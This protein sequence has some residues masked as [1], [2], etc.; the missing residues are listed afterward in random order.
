[1]FDREH[2]NSV[3]DITRRQARMQPDAVAQV[4]EGRVTTYGQLD[5]RS[6]RVAQ[7]FI[8]EGCKPDA[9]IG[10]IGKNSDRYFEMLHGAFKAKTVVVGVNWR[11]APPE[12]AYVLNDAK[13]EMIFVGAEFY[14]VVAQVVGECPT[15]RRV[16][17]LDGGHETWTSFDDWRDS[18][19]AT[20]PH[21]PDTMDD[22]VIQLYTSGTT[23]H[24]KGVQLTN[25]N[26]MA[27]LEEGQLSGWAKWNSD[28][29]V[30]V[31]MPLFHVAGVNI[32][33][34]GHAQ[35]TK[36]II[37]KD[38]DPQVI[39]RLI[40]QEK[41]N[42]AF[43]VPAVILFLLQQPN[44]NTTDVSSIR[45]ILYGASPIAEDVLKQ[46]QARFGCEF[47]QLYGLTETTGGA[48][49]LPPHAHDVAL[50]KLRSCGVP[51]PQTMIR[52]VDENGKDVPQG[53]VG[54]I[55]IKGGSVMKSYWNK[56][57]ATTESIKDGWFHSGDAGYFDADGYLYIHD[58]VK[59]MI[60]SGGENVYPAEVENALFGHPAIADVAVIGVPDERWGEA[61][62]A[63]VVLKPG[64]TAE[65]ADIIAF[66]KTRI[67][68]FKVPKS[69]D[70]V[71][72]LPRNPS[73]KIL[74]RELRSPYWEG[75][76]RM[77][78]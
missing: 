16:I 32:G 27:I 22:D 67:A 40:E 46:A 5:E 31:C 17:A 37:L 77:V 3:A 9:R 26:Y 74:R 29:V 54:E 57:Q 65:P 19:P 30:L 53:G 59:D 76:A 51:N 10:F 15:V 55:L 50:G 69:I 23:G 49:H 14:D 25:R 36:N 8:A 21:F 38:V 56:P 48:T 70:F 58:R 7:G 73:G 42:I 12:I 43:M 33:I 71:A 62:K 64:M 75:R 28:E 45:Q 61:V 44:I 39:L 47:V 24:P 18:F 13:A 68:G 41:I 20:D 60:V 35:G 72:A 1:M 78:N 66:A 2:I 34:I 11:L 63:C 4:F 52:I 6:N